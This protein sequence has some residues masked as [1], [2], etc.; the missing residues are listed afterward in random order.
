MLSKISQS[1]NQ[2]TSC[3]EN[4]KGRDHG[5]FANQ[6]DHQ[7]WEGVKSGQDEALAELYTRYANKLYNYGTQITLDHDLAFDIVQDVFLNLV[8]KKEKLGQILSIKNYLYASY[9]RALM[10]ALKRNKRL[11]FNEDY[12]RYDGF[13]VDIAEDFY[14]LST[15]LTIDVKKLLHK[16]SNEL[17]VRQR[18]IISLYFFE[19]LSYQEIAE[20]MAFT[21]VR[22]ARNL[23]YKALNSMSEVLKKHE[24]MLLLWVILMS[25]LR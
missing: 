7:I 18:E 10:R 14:A 13:H 22:S 19:Q 12:E 24:E 17:P 3:P 9:R 8:S 6:T 5:L 2:H 15:D 11:R 21:N 25:S 1:E 20:V 16:V 4:E 23:L